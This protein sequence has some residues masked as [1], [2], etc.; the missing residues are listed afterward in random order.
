[1]KANKTSDKLTEKQKSFCRHY[2]S[3]GFN[4]TQACISAGY[5]ENTAAV[6]GTENLIK[7]NIQHYISE[8]LKPKLEKLDITADTVLQEI[9]RIAFSN[10]TDFITS[11][12]EIKDI[13]TL[14]KQ[15]TIPVS[16]I[17]T[18][19]KTNEFGEEKTVSIE[20]WNKLEA[21][22]KLGE[23]LKL[24]NGDG[25]VTVIPMIQVSADVKKDIDNI[26]L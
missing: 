16:K 26:Q 18:T 23:Y 19:T 21:L 11:G 10:I 1:M 7:P 4:G 15:T 9:A 5:S 3:N 12:N 17:K 2:I 8:L 14:E 20:L 25:A 22:K 13:S 24:F 6:Q